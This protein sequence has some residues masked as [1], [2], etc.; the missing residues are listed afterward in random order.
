MGEI[1]VGITAWTEPTLIQS[2]R[3]YP[4]WANSA[5]A[6]LRFYASQFPIV[7]VDSSYY[8]MPAEKT[9][10][11]W[12]VRTP[13]RFVFDI[14]AFG[15]VFALGELVR[16]FLIAFLKRAQALE[17]PAQG[18][19]GDIQIVDG[20]DLGERQF[21]FVF[22]RGHTVLRLYNRRMLTLQG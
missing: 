1:L 16:E 11:L 21:G 6:R 4:D 18:H 7:E 8:A 9:A 2:G 17:G 15:R 10:G 3:F 13:D 12:V 5:E 14:K 19:P 22:V 20:L